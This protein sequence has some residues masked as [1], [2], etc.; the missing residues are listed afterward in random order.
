MNEILPWITLSVTCICT[1]LLLLWFYYAFIVTFNSAPYLP[2]GRKTVKEALT[3]AG[4]NE[5]TN[6][7]DIGSGDGRVVLLA[8]KIGAKSSTGIEINPFLSLFSKLVLKIGQAKKAQIIQGDMFKLNY[9]DYDVIYTYLLIDT[10]NNLL[11]LIRKSAKPGTIIV[12]NTF[13]FKELTPIQTI[14]KINIYRI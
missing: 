6:F 5:N 2:S 1:F 9:A 8:S 11:P 14:G 13:K 4:V 3:A 7:L 10:M 12:S